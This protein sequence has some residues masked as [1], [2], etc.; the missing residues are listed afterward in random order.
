M[1]KKNKDASANIIN[2]IDNLDFK[3][4]TYSNTKFNKLSYLPPY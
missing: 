4:F 2:E 3:Q 1:L